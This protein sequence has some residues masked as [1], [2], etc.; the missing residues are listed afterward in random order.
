MNI[1][2]QVVAKD[3]QQAEKENVFPGKM[4]QCCQCDHAY[5]QWPD[6]DH[7]KTIEMNIEI[8]AKI[9]DREFNKYQPEPTLQ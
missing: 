2:E 4:N 6:N 9:Y 7:V 3:Q 8:P 5:A 1:I